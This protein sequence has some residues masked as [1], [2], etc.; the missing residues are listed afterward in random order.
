MKNDEFINNVVDDDS[1]EDEINHKKQV[2]RRKNIEETQKILM[3]N[4][5]F[6][7]I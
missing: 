6:V 1:G 2:K 7:A 4:P 5:I 3:R